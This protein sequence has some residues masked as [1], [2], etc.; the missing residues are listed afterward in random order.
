[1]KPPVRRVERQ[2]EFWFG[3]APG[4][5][6]LVDNA[7]CDCDRVLMNLRTAEATSLAMMA[8]DIADAASAPPS[9]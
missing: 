7:P 3:P 4:Q 6:K 8:S 1:M 9:H 5:R 2:E